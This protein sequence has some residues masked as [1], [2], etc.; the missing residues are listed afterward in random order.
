MFEH[1]GNILVG[2][3]VIR[4]KGFEK[5]CHKTITLKIK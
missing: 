5:G 1:V 3:S 2:G 4:T